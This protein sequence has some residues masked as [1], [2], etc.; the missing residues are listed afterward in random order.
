MKRKASLLLLT[1]IPAL[2]VGALVLH[3]SGASPRLYGQNILCYVILGLPLCLASLR[4]IRLPRPQPLAM[5]LL[6]CA[7]LAL[8][9]LDRGL[10]NV[11]RW[12]GVGGFRL[13]L[14]SLMLPSGII[15]L[16]LML[17][18]DSGR[19]VALLLSAV[20]AGLLT[21]QPDASQLT[22][23]AAAAALLVW[24]GPTSRTLKYGVAL[25]GALLIL[26]SWLH[27]DM[28]PSVSPVEDILFLAK[29]MGILWFI[30]GL[31]SLVLLVL[32]FLTAFR[33]IPAAKALGVYYTAILAS[34]LWGSFPVPF[35]GYG[36]SPILGYL[37]A[38]FLLLLPPFS[39]RSRFSA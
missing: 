29:D 1:P 32:P 38:V 26:Y 20:I 22:G 19:A 25:A 21:L 33:G 23:F 10:E 9:F 13:Y 8:T 4:P 28:L 11:H 30:L 7:A 16:S 15:G 14:S 5:L 34:S 17:R 39:L 37:L 6:C 35:M 31:L 24:M 27:L 18:E 36:A 12:V 2:C 3:L